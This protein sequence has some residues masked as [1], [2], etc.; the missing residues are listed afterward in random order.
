[1]RTV[2]VGGGAAG[3]GAAGAARAAGPAEEV[4]VYAEFE[5]AAYSPCGIPYVHGRE[6]PD[7]DRF[8][9]WLRVFA[10]T[11]RRLPWKVRSA[12]IQRMPGSH[13]RD[14]SRHVNSTAGPA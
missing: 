7:F 14:W 2:I 4:P 8:I 5:D 10:P 1:M 9:F 3:I 12:F 11:Y 13:R 6:I